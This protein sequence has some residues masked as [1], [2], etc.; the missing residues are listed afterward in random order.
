MEQNRRQEIISKIVAKAK[1]LGV[2]ISPDEI[3]E[4]YILDFAVTIEHNELMQELRDLLTDYIDA[5]EEGDKTWT[6]V[7]DDKKRRRA[8]SK[9]LKDDAKGKGQ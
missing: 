1:E 7:R 5:R 8:L 2:T 9:K 6:S 4:A 3:T